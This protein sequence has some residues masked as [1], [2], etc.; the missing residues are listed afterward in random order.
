MINRV[1]I[2]GEVVYDP[3]FRITKSE[4][5]I[6]SF[7]VETI[8]RRRGVQGTGKVSEFHRVVCFGKRAELANESLEKGSRV[9]VE[10]KLNSH[11]YKIKGGDEQKTTQILA[12]H[13]LPFDGSPVDQ[14]DDF[15]EEEF[16]Q[17]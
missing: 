12:H 5:A 13:I 7:V 6:C 11:K 2:L 3:E 1:Q 4:E 16:P 14:R 10:G 17:T 8:E 9:F 15:N